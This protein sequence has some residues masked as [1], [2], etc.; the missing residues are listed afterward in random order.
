M[1]DTKPCTTRRSI[2]AR[3][4]A[5]AGMGVLII[6]VDARK[7]AAA[8]TSKAA[9]LYQ[10]HPHEGRR[11]GDCKFFSTDNGANAGTCALV[12]GPVDRNG[13][14]MAFSPRS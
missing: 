4:L 10:E 2:L 5:L 6:A 11:C 7:L 1:H 8:K 3:G 9:M 14:C 12:E 13:W